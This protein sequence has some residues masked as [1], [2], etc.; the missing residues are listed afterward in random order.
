MP[1][2][3]GLFQ[4]FVTDGARLE[5]LMIVFLCSF[6][7]GPGREIMILDLLYLMRQKTSLTKIAF[8]RLCWTMDI[9]FLKQIFT[10]EYH[11]ES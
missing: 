3:I 10:H 5:S 7:W 6:P 8:Y 4:Y 1:L 2:K 11:F 9:T